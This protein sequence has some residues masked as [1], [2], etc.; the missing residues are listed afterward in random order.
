MLDDQQRAGEVGQP[1]FAE[2]LDDRARNGIVEAGDVDDELL[3]ET[4]ARP[5]PRPESLR[6]R[7]LRHGLDSFLLEPGGDRRPGCAPR[8]LGRAAEQHGHAQPAEF[9]QHGV[10]RC[11]RRLRYRIERIAHVRLSV[12]DR[13][14]KTS[15]LDRSNKA[16]TTR[17]LTPVSGTVGATLGGRRP[18]D[19]WAEDRHAASRCRSALTTA[20]GELHTPGTVRAAAMSGDGRH[21]GR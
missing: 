19:R 1:F 7:P 4:E 11:P 12:Q 18:A 6:P 16:G 20:G 13:R 2:V 3:G 15:S 10:D 5:L 17:K 8:Q 14:A 21:G 9:Q